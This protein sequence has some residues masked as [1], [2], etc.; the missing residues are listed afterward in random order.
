M[1]STIEGELE[2]RQVL[3]DAAALGEQV[4]VVVR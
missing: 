2:A 1:P 3:A 4:Q